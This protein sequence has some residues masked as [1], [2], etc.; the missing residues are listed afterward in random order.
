MPYCTPSDM[1]AHGV[2]RGA[3]PNPGRVL[4]SAL[5]NVCTLDQH[6][7]ET[8]DE[9][10]FRPAGDG[11]MPAGLTAGTTYYAQ[12]ETEHTFRVRATAGGAALTFTDATDPLVVIAPLDKDAAIEYADRLIDDMVPGQA[13]P[14]DDTTLYPDGVPAIIRMTSAELASVKLLSGSGAASKSLADVADWAHKRLTRWSLGLPVRETPDQSRQNL[15]AVAV[16]PYE[17]R[18]GWSRYGGL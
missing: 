9:V 11:D 12:L 13:V 3:T 17:D 8:G 15:A 6:G 1:H 5:S 10:L 4:A 16:A 7:F 2:P 18:R 14:F